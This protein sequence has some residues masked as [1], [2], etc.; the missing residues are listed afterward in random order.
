VGHR[1]DLGQRL[2]RVVLN[3]GRMMIECAVVRAA[4]GVLTAKQAPHRPG[5]APAPGPRAGCGVISILPRTKR[6]SAM[7]LMKRSV[8]RVESLEDRWLPSADFVLQW[9]SLLVNVQQ[10]RG[11]GNQ[12][13]AR[14]L[15]MMG[16]AVYDSVNA[17]DPTHTVY[18][19]DAR[20]F[21]NVSA[22]SPD[23]AA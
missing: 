11:Q 1:H 17:I 18:H 19:V 4:G 16:A 21:P 13:A 8:L 20:T 23:A 14:A 10:T 7:K 3:N 6:D 5:T 15:A 12:V 22:A 2:L 9:N